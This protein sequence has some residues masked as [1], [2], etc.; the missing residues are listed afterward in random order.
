MWLE[1]GQRRRNWKPHTL[2]AYR[3]AIGYLDDYFGSTRLAAIRPR[4]V[5][6]YVSHSLTEPHQRLRRP[7]SAKTLELH[8][9]VLHDLFRTAVAEEVLDSNPDAG[10]ERPRVQRQRWRILE[11]DEVRRV[12]N[13]FTNRRARTV[14]LT[15]ILTGVRRCELVSLR[16]Q[17]VSLT[18]G[19]LRVAESKSDE[20]LRLIQMPSMLTAALVDHYSQATYTSDTDYVFAHPERGSRLD[21]DWYRDHFKDALAEAGIEGRV[22]AFHD[23]RHS[24]LTNLALTS[25]ANELVLMATAG[26]RSFATTKQYLHLAGR[27]F[28][29]AAEALQDRLLGANFVPRLYPSE[30]ISADLSEPNSALQAEN[31]SA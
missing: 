10:V 22:R 17:H 8:L 12:A 3:N 23:M 31:G 7:M 5:A 14:F 15:L 2:S 26:H 25:E 30:P 21:P 29:D 9:S 13:A 18:E 16:W 4:D 28:P 19:T 27:V 20:G 6:G 1:E 11:P 24:A